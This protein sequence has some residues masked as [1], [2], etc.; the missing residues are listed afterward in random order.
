MRNSRGAGRTPTRVSEGPKRTRRSNRCE[1][2]PP[3]DHRESEA[4]SF[5]SD[6]WAAVR[7]ARLDPMQPVPD[8][9][10]GE[11]SRFLGTKRWKSQ[12]LRQLSPE[13]RS[14]WKASEGVSGQLSAHH[15]L[16]LC[17]HFA[18]SGPGLSFATGPRFNIRQSPAIVHSATLL[19]TS[20]S[21]C[22][23]QLIYAVIASGQVSA[24]TPE[25][26]C[27]CEAR[28]KLQHSRQARRGQRP[29]PSP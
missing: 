9:G 3:G 21:V 1:C 28:R 22:L 27:G 12:K 25:A 24:S 13:Q 14:D 15:S 29:F 11:S 17:C 20:S 16:R 26:F 6:P 5:R 18:G 19:A 8:S 2:V 4:Q 23:K 10:G 7:R